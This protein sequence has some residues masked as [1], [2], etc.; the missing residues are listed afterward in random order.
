MRHRKEPTYVHFASKGGGSIN[1]G[2]LYGVCC[3]GQYKE[4][5]HKQIKFFKSSRCLRS[6][7]EGFIY[8]LDEGLFGRVDTFRY[9]EMPP[10]SLRDVCAAPPIVGH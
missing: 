7:R 5:R 8:M 6:R 3:N 9:F 10:F 1:R 2:I 4:V